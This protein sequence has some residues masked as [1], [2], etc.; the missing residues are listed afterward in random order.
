M[1]KH[2]KVLLALTLAVL[3]STSLLFMRRLATQEVYDDTAGFYT[4]HDG[5]VSFG[6]VFVNGIKL[7]N[8]YSYNTGIKGEP[9]YLPLYDILFELG[10]TI[11]VI[12]GIPVRRGEPLSYS[13]HR[14]SILGLKGK[15]VTNVGQDWFLLDNERMI[16][17]YAVKETE[18][19]NLYASMHFFMDVFGVDSITFEYGD[20]HINSVVVDWMAAMRMRQPTIPSS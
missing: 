6:H 10:S 2:N 20:V 17:S 7:Q 1:G 8:V 5:D 14:I 18:P 3:V 4:R 19:G 13:G 15:I 12:D 16:S 11:S 9:I